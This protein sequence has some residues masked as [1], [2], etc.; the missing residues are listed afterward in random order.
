M[1]INEKIVK[2]KQA[3]AFRGRGDSGREVDEDYGDE[4]V[5]PGQHIVNN[6]PVLDLGYKPE[7]LLEEWS[8]TMDGFI[9][10]PVTWKWEDFQ[11]QPLFKSS[12][13]FHCV[14]TWS[15]LDNDL[16]I[17]SSTCSFSL[18]Q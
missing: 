15:R 4:R 1:E 16:L 14:T 5:P 11:A 12:S 13:D 7:V 6:W 9:T 2:A 8:L 18:K 10:H 17:Q 3:L